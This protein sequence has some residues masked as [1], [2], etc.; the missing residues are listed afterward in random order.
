MNSPE[1]QPVSSQ[2]GLIRPIRSGF[3]VAA[4]HIILLLFP[5]LLDLWIWLGVHL[6]MGTTMKNFWVEIEQLMIGSVERIDQ[7]MEF[8][9]QLLVERLNL[10]VALRSF[11]VGIPSLMSSR[12]PIDAPFG[13]PVV[14]DVISITNGILWF[15]ALAIIGLALGT[16]YYLVVS[17]AA[18]NGSP[19]WRAAL[20]DWPWAFWQVITLTVVWICFAIAISIP[21]SCLVPVVSVGGFSQ[22]LGFIYL[23]VMVWFFFPLLLSAHGIFVNREK[24][25]VSLLKSVNLT[26]MT[27]PVTS[28][29]ILIAFFIMQGF[30]I[31]WGWP[32]ENSWLVLIGLAGHGFV[33][34]AILAASF[35]Y[36]READQWA[37][38]FVRQMMLQRQS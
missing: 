26:R 30:D 28:F 27:L 16:Y 25:I 2:P 24:M 35:I 31:V 32:Q 37:Q 34:N 33:A 6:S 12:W 19:R 7:M 14:V 8:S 23:A 3:N 18:L 11:P 10:M 21:F 17:Q 38:R 1:S 22:F 29:F 13:S 9:R 36:Y 20:R 5:V 15:V 4:N